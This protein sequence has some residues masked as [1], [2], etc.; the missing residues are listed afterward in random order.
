MLVRLKRYLFKN[1]LFISFVYI[2]SCNLKSIEK[3][4]ATIGTGFYGI[5]EK[6]VIE[7]QEILSQNNVALRHVE[8]T[9]VIV[10]IKKG[11]DDK[12]YTVKRK[13]S[14]GGLIIQ[15]IV[16]DGLSAAFSNNETGTELLDFLFYEKSDGS[17]NNNLA[18]GD[19]DIRVV[20][21]NESQTSN[22]K[23]LEYQKFNTHI[24]RC[25]YKD[26]ELILEEIDLK[27][28]IE[29]IKANNT[30]VGQVD[31]IAKKIFNFTEDDML[32]NKLNY[33]ISGDLVNLD[34][35]FKREFKKVLKEAKEKKGAEKTLLYSGKVSKL[36]TTPVDRGWYIT[37]KLNNGEVKVGFYELKANFEKFDT[38]EEMAKLQK[39]DTITN[40]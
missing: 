10:K 4:K 17:G 9:G 6:A 3:Y 39:K 23:R 12:Y 5:S 1:I 19:D 21:L 32:E 11:S 22:D 7:L 35:D 25:V 18:F 15:E 37:M 2:I 28:L 34:E 33:Y 14:E 38:K 13:K 8:E 30:L 24:A 29:K 16:G 40:P 20:S 36:F 31:L 27:D 26:G